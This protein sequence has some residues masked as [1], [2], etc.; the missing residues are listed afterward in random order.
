[1]QVETS[2]T[3]PPRVPAE[4]WMTVSPKLEMPGGRAVLAETVR[5]ANEI[6]MPVG[7]DADVAALRRLL[8]ETGARAPVFL[9]PLSRS[10]KATRLCIEAATRFG[11]R[12]SIQTH[13]YL[14]LR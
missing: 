8:R 3:E 4:V 2:G 10:P 6:K 7:R 1:V 14:G 11:W 9:Q 5:R 12:V 13:A